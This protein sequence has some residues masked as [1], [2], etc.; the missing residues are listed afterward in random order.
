MVSQRNEWMKLIRFLS[1]FILGFTSIPIFGQL[2]SLKKIKIAAQNEAVSLQPGDST[3]ILIKAEIMPG[4]HV[5]WE[6]SGQTG[7]P[8]SIKWELPKGISVS[9]LQFPTPEYYEFQ[10]LVSYV[11][12]DSL[13]L[14]AKL[15]LDQDM[16][17][18]GSLK[19][20]GNFSTLICNES[21]CIPFR[22]EFLISVEIGSSTKLNPEISR[23]VQMAKAKWPIPLPAASISSMEAGTEFV[24]LSFYNE[25]FQDLK[26]NEFYFFPIG[27]FIEHGTRQIFSADSN[28]TTVGLRLKRASGVSPPDRIEGVLYHPALERSYRIDLEQERIIYGKKLKKEMAQQREMNISYSDKDFRILYVWLSFLVMALA[29]WIYGRT[30][31]L[32]HSKV[33]KRV[34]AV[35]VILTLGFAVWLGYP[36]KSIPTGGLKWVEW[37]PELEKSLRAE[38]KAVYVDFT[39]KWCLSCQVNKR[40]FLYDDVVEAFKNKQIVPLIA[41]WTNKGTQIL[42]ALQSFGREGVPLNVYYPPSG[43]GILLP[44]ILSEKIVLSVLE[45]EKPYFEEQADGFWSI[46]SFAFIGGMILNLMPCVFPVLGLKV[47]SFVKQSGGEVQRI[48]KHG[49]VFTIGVLLSFWI[50][51]GLL[52]LLREKMEDSLGWGFQ[53]Q[54]PLFVLVLA[55]I[56]FVFALSLSGVLDIG[57]S[58]TGIGSKISRADGYTGSF[59][60][61]ILATV[62]STPCMA[63]F[64]GV[65]VGTALTMDWLGAYA[66]FT[67]IALGLSLPYLLLSIFP[68]WVSK[69][70][71]PGEWMETFKQFMA[72]PMYA[73]VIWLLWTLQS[74]L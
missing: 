7:F 35:L 55:I 16:N 32:H 14:L 17:S 42:S 31:Q 19:V 68:A 73:T 62:V 50:L 61:G 34:G 52:L 53:L 10:G 1:I 13:I 59:F 39:A 69:L 49:F 9:S 38:G 25:N 26:T 65:A 6:S 51:L 47:M 41:D 64:L 23:T 48:K 54:E 40:V 43:E 60:S 36:N 18:S 70:P 20:K 12:K 71:K 3:W 45:T 2:G 8:T 15:K 22:S 29:I 63:P 37:S 5:Y 24:D 66:V 74:L 30:N 56:L 27:G 44:E 11:H 4:W 46:L 21:T 72:F 28:G 58:L 57:N 33:K 67:C